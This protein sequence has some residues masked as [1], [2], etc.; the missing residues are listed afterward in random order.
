MRDK[1]SCDVKELPT[2]MWDILYA[3][4]VLSCKSEEDVV[5][6]MASF[7]LISRKHRL[8]ASGPKF[9]AYLQAFKNSDN[10]NDRICRYFVSP[11]ESQF[12][13]ADIRFLMLHPSFIPNIHLCFMPEDQSDL[14]NEYGKYCG[15]RVRLLTRIYTHS[16]VHIVVLALKDKTFNW[17]KYFLQRDEGLSKVSS[18]IMSKISIAKAQLNNVLS[19]TQSIIDIDD[20]TNFSVLREFVPN[21]VHESFS[22]NVE[23]TYT[24]NPLEYAAK[25]NKT[26]TVKYINRTVPDCT[27]KFGILNNALEL[28]SIDRNIFMS[29]FKRDAKLF[30]KEHVDTLFNTLCF[31]A[32]DEMIKYFLAKGQ[33]P[34]FAD[35]LNAIGS[36]DVETLKL[37]FNAF[38]KK[39]SDTAKHKAIQYVLI[40]SSEQQ[41]SMLFEF[42]FD[43][44][45]INILEVLQSS[46]NIYDPLFSYDYLLLCLALIRSGKC[47][48]ILQEVDKDGNNLL[49]FLCLFILEPEVYSFI[50]ENS[51][52]LFQTNKIGQLPIHCFCENS[53][54]RTDTLSAFNILFAFAK[55]DTNFRMLFTPNPTSGRTLMSP[56]LDLLDSLGDI[57]NSTEKS[58]EDCL[59]SA[60]NKSNTINIIKAVAEKEGLTPIH[61]LAKNIRNRKRFSRF[62]NQLFPNMLLDI[63]STDGRNVLHSIFSSQNYRM[64]KVIARNYSPLE[65]LLAKRDKHGKIPYECIDHFEHHRVNKFLDLPLGKLTVR[66]YCLKLIEHRKA[67]EGFLTRMAAHKGIDPDKAV[68]LKEM[69]TKLQSSDFTLEQLLKYIHEV[70][71]TCKAAEGG[72]VGFISFSWM[73]D[74]QSYLEFVKEFDDNNNPKAPRP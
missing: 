49:H 24:L 39:A 26:N 18:S 31:I 15:Y 70:R 66:T 12:S 65:L 32:D 50:S 38:M 62:K 41:L 33:Q 10:L 14:H 2:E 45:N 25:N 40:L 8:V 51:N 28:G 23:N 69:L 55:I 64:L 4:M 42:I 3:Y 63:V 47:K 34:N 59:F 5:G 21:V 67:L 72:I 74:S 57:D 43:D 17:L 19:L 13:A 36:E 22:L 44:Y 35:L 6:L 29:I 54:I 68:K 9:R 11:S 58:G 46:L 48:E 53:C 20:T 60:E 71:M 37:V 16:A 61:Y 73:R 56:I 7:K 30:T 27:L 1:D 52:L